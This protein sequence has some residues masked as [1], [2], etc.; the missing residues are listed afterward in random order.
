M[1]GMQIHPLSLK[2]I[3]QG[4]PWIT[5]DEYSSKFPK[6]KNILKVFEP[7]SNK[8]LGTFIHD[9]KHP[10]VV[11]RFWSSNPGS[12]DKQFLKKLSEALNKRK[13]LLDKRENIY[14][15]FAEADGLPGLFIQKLGD[16]ILIQYECFF[17]EELLEQIVSFYQRCE[18]I[19]GVK[20]YWTQKRIPGEDKKHPIPYFENQESEVIVCEGD[21]KFKVKFNLNH[22]IGLY[23]DMSAIRDMLYN[24]FKSASTSLN[25]FSYTGAFSLMGLK[26]GHEVTSVDLS[27]KYMSWLEENIR[28]NSFDEKKHNSMVMAGDKALKKFNEDKTRFDL[29]ICDPPSFFT[30]K[31][32][33][34]SSKDFYKENLNTLLNCLNKNGRAIIFLNTHQ[35]NQKQFSNLVKDILKRIP[36]VRIEKQLFMSQDCKPLANFSEGNYL[37][38]FILN[39]N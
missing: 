5:K 3:Q 8:L 14:L 6:E 15:A 13:P 18:K 35:V 33:R 23:T 17:W 2:S 16:N 37:K 39:K 19:L 25:L 11:A 26:H 27:S 4:H 22:D 1:K 7:N 12:F 24:E 20:N 29:I 31:K 38:C 30:D 34:K 10:R 9:P 21:I 28:I 32:K 36:D